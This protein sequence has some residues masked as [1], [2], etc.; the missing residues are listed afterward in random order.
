MPPRDWPDQFHCVCVK[1]EFVSD[2]ND[3]YPIL[4]F[5]RETVVDQVV[6]VQC[7]VGPDFQGPPGPQ[8][9][10][11][12]TSPNEPVWTAYVSEVPDL[13]GVAEGLGPLWT[14]RVRTDLGFVTIQERGE[15]EIS[16]SR[17]VFQA[18][19]VLRI[20]C[21]IEDP[22][23]AYQALVYVRYRTRRA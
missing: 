9:T 16:L 14:G 10:D 23:E 22:D 17:N 12:D 8:N 18:G 20:R 15:G 1:L 21:G 19:E 7:G 11:D 6:V 4:H 3:A 2:D 5:D 13:A